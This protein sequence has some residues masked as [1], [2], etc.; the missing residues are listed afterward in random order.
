MA[1][2]F[3]AATTLPSSSIAN[4]RQKFSAA[5]EK[6]HGG[7]QGRGDPFSAGGVSVEKRKVPH[8]LELSDRHLE[9]RIQCKHYWIHC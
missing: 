9:A 6:Q 8:P 5:A 1:T 3:Y 4:N 7:R 2:A